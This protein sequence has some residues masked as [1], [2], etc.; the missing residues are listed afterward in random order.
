MELQSVI[1]VRLEDMDPIVRT[2][3]E[4]VRW[5]CIY[6]CFPTP[7]VGDGGQ[8]YFDVMPRPPSPTPL[9]LQSTQK[10]EAHSHTRDL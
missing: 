10:N 5:S 2:L 8:A 3:E 7:N 6:T 1:L 4:P 9:N